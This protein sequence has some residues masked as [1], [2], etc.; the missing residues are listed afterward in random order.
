MYIVKISSDSSVRAQREE[1]VSLELNSGNF[2]IMTAKG[3]LK[4][5]KSMLEA[6]SQDGENRDTFVK[7]AWQLIDALDLDDICERG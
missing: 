5:V 3:I 7:A 2:R 6:A 4:E 1:T